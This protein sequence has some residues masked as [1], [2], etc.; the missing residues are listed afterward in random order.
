MKRKMALYIKHLRHAAHSALEPMALK[1]DDNIRTIEEAKSKR[2]LT[3]EEG[4]LLDR[5]K[6]IQGDLED[7]LKNKLKEVEALADEDK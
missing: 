4:I 6:K 2:S 3:V 7:F 1:I 5:Q